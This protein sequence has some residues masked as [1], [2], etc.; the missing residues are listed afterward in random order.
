MKGRKIAGGM[1]ALG[2]CWGMGQLNLRAQQAGGAPDPLL[3]ADRK[4]EA[5]VRDHNEVAKNLKYLADEI[6]PRLTGSVNL[7]RASHWTQ[8]RFTEYGLGNAHLEPWT[9]AHGWTRGTA[10]AR[11]VSPIGHPMVIA[12]A[13]WAPNTNGAVQGPVVYMK[14]KKVEDLAQYKGKVRGAMVIASEPFD[15]NAPK[16]PMLTPYSEEIIPINL[17]KKQERV[18]RDPAFYQALFQFMKTEGV[19]AVLLSSDKPYGLLNMFGIGGPLYFEGQTPT[20][21]IGWEDYN[22]IWRLLQKGPVQLEVNISGNGFSEKPVGVY[23]TVAEIKGTEKPDEVVIVGAHLDSWDLGTG[24]TDNGTGTAAVLEAARALEKTGLKPKRTIRFVLFTGE[25]QGLCGSHAYVMAH[26]AEMG[27]ISGVLV[28]DTGTSKV[29]S[30]GMM[31]FYEDREAMDKVLAPMK[32]LGLLEPSLRSLYG[33]AHNSFDA[34]GVPGFWAIQEVGDY[35]QT[36][37]SQAD[38]YDRVKPAELM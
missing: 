13:G 9:V 15:F 14:V 11:I 25:E 16:N 21:I 10:E 6:G 26:Q 8:Q 36:H 33:S 35:P 18:R 32:D 30:I 3:E 19:A 1:L 37:H 7:D 17:P 12:S 4:I 34:V 24:A 27:K 5:E 29:I 28:H 20:A 38:T 31:G 22:L 23:N 2:L